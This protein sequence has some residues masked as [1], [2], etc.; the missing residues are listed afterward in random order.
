MARLVLSQVDGRATIA[1]IA[2]ASGIP[3]DLACRIAEALER[4]G[5]IVFPGAGTA[6]SYADPEIAGGGG[7]ESD[8]LE[9]DV[10]K[11]AAE[12]SGLNYYEMLSV[13][14]DADRKALRSA[15]F[16][17]SK[18]YHPDRAFGPKRAELRKQMEAIFTRLSRAYETLSSPEERAAYDAYIAE[19]IELWKIERQLRDA[20]ALSRKLEAPAGVTPTPEPVAPSRSSAP[21]VVVTQTRSSSPSAGARKRA[22][23]TSIPAERHPP[24]KVPDATT[25]PPDDAGERRLQWKKERLGRALGMVLSQAPAP[26]SKQTSRELEEQVSQAAMAIEL[27]KHA[28]AVH[29]LQEVLAENG[30]MPRAR[31]LLRRAEAGATK[32]LSLGYLRQARY[33]RQHGDPEVARAHF[34]KAISIDPSSLDARHQLAEMLIEHK[35]DLRKA[36]TLCREVIGLGGQRAKYFVTLGEILLLSKD[37]ERAADAFAHALALEPDNKELKKKLKACRG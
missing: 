36:L 4:D 37:K 17:L 29:I 15:Y 10:E 5:R 30:D 6:G 16:M 28:N 26:P 24:Q 34:E 18:R 1:D 33:E 9:A 2:D 20:V 12:M 14:P 7:A 32:E 22:I 25:P 21:A 8:S 11:L 27:G 13:E 35:L 19:Q 3:A 23:V 31:D